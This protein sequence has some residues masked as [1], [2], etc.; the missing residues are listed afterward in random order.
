MR[1]GTSQ[2]NN[3]EARREIARA[4]AL[5]SNVSL[6][7]F[8]EVDNDKADILIKFEKY[9][10]SLT[11]GMI[12]IN[13]PNNVVEE[14]MATSINSM[15]RPTRWPTHFFQAVA[16]EVTPI[17]TMMRVGFITNEMLKVNS[18]K[19][20]QIF[21]DF[22]DFFRIIFS[23]F[24]SGFLDF[25]D[26]FPIFFGFLGFFRILKKKIRDFFYFFSDFLDFLDFFSDFFGCKRIL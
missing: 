2:I 12:F 20:F 17:S 1:K 7:N 25:L 19:F 18:K 11:F 3:G 15:D 16:S 10:Q 22:L 26:F 23:D 4:L 21:S 6:L 24:F 5:W 14:I 8:N 13:E 9:V